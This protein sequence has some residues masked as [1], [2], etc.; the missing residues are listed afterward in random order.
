MLPIQWYDKVIIWNRELEI[1]E[2]VPPNV[3]G[4]SAN[5]RVGKCRLNSQHLY[6]Q[7]CNWMCVL[8]LITSTS[9]SQ[10]EESRLPI[11]ARRVN[12]QKLSWTRELLWPFRHGIFLLPA[13]CTHE[14]LLLRMHAYFRNVIFKSIA[15]YVKCPFFWWETKNA[16][17]SGRLSVTR[18][19]R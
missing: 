4:P 17:R 15:M 3:R 16:S 9:I 11:W 7:W 6:W 18:R 5:G 10:S 2:I 19:L 8:F 13:G 1:A 14:I 12:T